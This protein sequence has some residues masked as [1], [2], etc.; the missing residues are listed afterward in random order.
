V[1]LAVQEKAV[2]CLRILTTGN[3]ANR[4]ALYSNHAAVSAIV[5]LTQHRSE[6]VRPSSYVLSNAQVV[7]EVVVAFLHKPSTCFFKTPA[8]TL[9]M[10]EVVVAF[11][12]KP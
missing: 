2:D 10:V 3:D 8:L 9:L 11:L 6:A 12:D 7:V 4:H 5:R 1:A